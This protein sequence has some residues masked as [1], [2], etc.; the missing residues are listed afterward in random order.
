MPMQLFNRCLVLALLAVCIACGNQAETNN[1]NSPQAA[2]AQEE[3]S[4][5]FE[6]YRKEQEERAR[7]IQTLDEAI[8]E[9][10]RDSVQV[11]PVV[12][13]G[14]YVVTQYG[15]WLLKDSSA[16]RVTSNPVSSLNSGGPTVK[17]KANDFWALWQTERA[18]LT[19]TKTKAR[20]SARGY[21]SQI[22]E[23]E[24]EIEELKSKVREME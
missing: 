3:K 15:V 7:H 16:Y 21:E 12:G 19:K 13:G 1:S 6:D 8:R 10:L 2:S 24:R 18:N 9:S 14:A 23:L 11:V 22:E 5:P 4:D 20:E 17:P